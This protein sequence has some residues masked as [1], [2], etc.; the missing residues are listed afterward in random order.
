MESEAALYDNK[1]A[2]LKS[3]SNKISPI[4]H[5]LA[6]TKLARTS[7]NYAAAT[8]RHQN[9]VCFRNERSV[10]GII[11]PALGNRFRRKSQ[12][13]AYR[14]YSYS[15][16][17]NA[18]LI[19]NI[20]SILVKHSF[21]FM[22]MIYKVSNESI[23]SIC[24][25]ISINVILCILTFFKK[26]AN[27][28]L[29]YLAFGT[30]LTLTLE[31]QTVYGLRIL[32]HQTETDVS[33]WNIDLVW[34]GLYVLFV[35]YALLPL[36]LRTSIVLG[37]I[38][39]F[40]HLATSVMGLINE[41]ETSHLTDELESGANAVLFLSVNGICVYIKYL[42]DRA[43]RST[44]LETKRSV[45]TR[46]KMQKENE[47]QEK[48][49]LSV[50]PK[51]VAKEMITDI[52]K[53]EEK[54]DFIPGQFH[55]IYIHRFE[56]ISILFADIKGFTEL[57]SKCTACQLV[58]V[59]NEL[60][61]RFDRLAE[62]NNCHRIKLLGDCYYC[63]CGLPD[64]RP[65]HAQC[66]V[67]MGLHMIR[68]IKR[69]RNKTKVDLDMRIG[70]HSGAVLCGVLGL[71][72]WQFDVWSNDVTV[73]NHMEQGG[74]PGRIHISE[75]TLRYLDGSYE[76]EDGDGESRDPYLAKHSVT[77]YLIKNQEPLHS[78]KKLRHRRRYA[79]VKTL[80]K[81]IEV[82]ARNDAAIQRNSN[83]SGTTS[84]LASTNSTVTLSVIDDDE[85]T[86]KWSP[87]LPFNNLDGSSDHDDD[88]IT[89]EDVLT[90]STEDI[91][92]N[93]SLEEG[94]LDLTDMNIEVSTNKHMTKVHINPL[95]LTFKSTLL[96]LAVS[97][98]ISW[99]L[100]RAPIRC[101]E[102][103]NGRFLRYNCSIQS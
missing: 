103:L 79:K 76:V 1:S 40:I 55:K 43:Q 84:R 35:T 47:K 73:A 86:S 91:R 63:V 49:L 56:D 27:R 52:A 41:H 36:S 66:C 62:E 23:I 32:K 30:W 83:E 21:I 5:G 46:S 2:S 82:L 17:K 13:F 102:A 64:P 20:I 10:K 50:L 12:E 28:Y 67:E 98:R 9:Q 68:A 54:G 65:D 19:V 101:I 33:H 53:E 96:E 77:T 95:T 97:I 90:G 45:E 92:K 81:D 87:E 3:T 24:V 99:P 61:A 85:N 93:E 7:A 26:I 60:Y 44:F 71:T 38:N 4:N 42:T 29:H 88:S 70:I 80:S 39:T 100:H 78:K 14:Q 8:Y 75:C 51:F 25:W 15:Q 34:G 22:T 94:F 18:V 69:V 72:K 57:A 58:S 48:L 37:G 6:V 74:I 59:L 11:V 16:R 31:G 89:S